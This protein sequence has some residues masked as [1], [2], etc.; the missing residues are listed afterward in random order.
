LYS[1][2]S[3]FSNEIGSTFTFNFSTNI[4]IIYNFFFRLINLLCWIID[5]SFS[6]FRSYLYF[7]FID[8]FIF[9]RLF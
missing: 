3:I 7:C 1:L 2:V 9:K 6:I 8:C 5:N 4:L